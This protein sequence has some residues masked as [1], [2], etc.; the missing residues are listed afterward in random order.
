MADVQRVKT[1]EEIGEKYKWKVDKIYS[2]LEQWEKDFQ[3]LK[4]LVPEVEKY[5]GKLSDKNQLKECLEL[6]EKVERLAGKLSVYASLRGDEDTANT[7]YQALRDKISSYMAELR[8]KTS[9][10]VPELL[11]IPED[12][13][14]EFIQSGDECKM[15]EFF[16]KDILKTK[17]HVLS[18]EKEELMAAVSD[19][20]QAPENIH[21][22]LTDADMTFPMIKDENGNEVELTESNYSVFIRSKDRRVRQEAFKALFSTYGKYKNTL[23][24]ALGGSM[25]NFIFNS[26]VRNYSSSLES[27]LKPNN[28]PVEVY[29]NT[30]D[31][32]NKNIEALH[33][34]V[35]VKKKLLGLAE[36]HMYD[37]YV[38]VIDMPSEFISFE[39]GVELAKQGLKPMGEEYLGIFD[40]GIRDGWIDVY[41]NRGKRG[42]AYSSGD[43]DTMPYILLNYENKLDDVSTLVH[44]MGHSIHSYYS[45][46]TQPYIYSDYSLFCAEVASTTNEILLINHLIENEKD[47]KK[48]LFLVNQ[49]LEQIRTTVFRQ[50]MFAEFEKIAHEK[51]ENGAA[52][53]CEDYSSIWHD[54]N[55]KYFGPDMIVDEEIDMEWARIPH[56]YWD[57]YVYQY[58]TGYSAAN[59]F[60]RMILDGGNEAV[61]KYVGFLKSGG[62]AYPIDVLRRAGV[63]MATPKPIEDAISRFNELLDMIE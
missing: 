53:T 29:E 27:S 45:R 36:M 34:Y 61:E 10:F 46:K 1:R 44:E 25:K 48:K 39:D 57:F 59:S 63:D 30:V 3:T 21:S 14:Q 41:N 51:M 12:K 19:C 8:S 32:I 56:F 38:P 58:A 16:L 28:I 20:L 15:Y 5:A 37:L 52:L 7:K 23:G 49:Q 62:N 17:P 60:A 35:R 42:G 6:Q 22:M 18:K 50:V 26:K 40:Q 2:S 55:V 4:S 43:Y 24:T 33:R 54:L 47:H 9:F 13:I 11:D 31:A